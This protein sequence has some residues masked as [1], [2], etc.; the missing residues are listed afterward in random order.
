MAHC[1]ALE[2]IDDYRWECRITGKTITLSDDCY[3]DGFSD[4]SCSDFQDKD[5]DFNRDFDPYND[6]DPKN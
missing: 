1:V 5:E 6:E 2:K 4:P 3:S